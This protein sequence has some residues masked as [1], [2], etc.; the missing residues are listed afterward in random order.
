MAFLR[1]GAITVEGRS[2]QPVTLRPEEDRS[3]NLYAMTDTM[4]E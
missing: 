4:K 3:I 2:F 1:E